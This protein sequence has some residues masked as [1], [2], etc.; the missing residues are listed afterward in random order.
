[1]VKALE[2]MKEPTRQALMDSVRNMDTEIPMLLP[3]IKVQTTPEDGFPIEAMQIMRFDGENWQ[4]Q[5]DVIE[6]EADGN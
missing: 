4:L 6:A 1:M 3:G 2:G 5:G